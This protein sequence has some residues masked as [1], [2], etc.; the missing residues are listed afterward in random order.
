[1]KASL[2]KQ[3]IPLA[4]KPLLLHTLERFHQALPTARLILVL[5]AEHLGLWKEI[6]QNHRCTIP[7][8]ITEGGDSRFQ[9]VKN[10]LLE[11]EGGLTAIHDGVRPLPSSGLIRHCFNQAGLFG[12]AVPVLP[13]SD[14]IRQVDEQG[15]RVIDRRTLRATQTPQCFNTELIKSAYFRAQSPDYT[16]C[17]SILESEGIPVHLVE[18]EISNLKITY[19]EDLNYAS[20]LLGSQK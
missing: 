12:S 16:D 10:G 3:F 8:T 11:V 7:H 9:S 5:P 18:G 20:Y 4:G 2:P 17:A 6:C 13:L 14:T 15:T 19:P 1:M